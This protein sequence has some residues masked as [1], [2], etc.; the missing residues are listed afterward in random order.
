V[1][2]DEF[3]Q[4]AAAIAAESL[5]ETDEATAISA[6]R[7]VEPS[8]H[9]PVEVEA[10]T[11]FRQIYAEPLGCAYGGSLF[12]ACWSDNGLLGE[13]LMAKKVAYAYPAYIELTPESGE[14]AR[15]GGVF[16][17]LAQVLRHPHLQRRVLDKRAF[18]RFRATMRK[19]NHLI[20]IDPQSI[21]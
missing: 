5:P 11:T 3:K 7:A 15:T 1:G 2:V 17:P 19:R 6:H 13:N 9:R 18:N 20:E 21:N 12:A 10:A 14:E 16:V 8:G 4:R